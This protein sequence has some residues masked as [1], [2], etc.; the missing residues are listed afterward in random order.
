MD[1]LTWLLLAVLAVCGLA[2]WWVRSSQ[3]RLD[4]TLHLAGL[5]APVTVMRDDRGI[6]HIT[7][8]NVHDLYMAQGYVMAQDRLWQMDLM[9]RLGEG[10]L[11]EIFGPA[12]LDLDRKNRE[13][14]LGRTAAAEA[15][16]L[17][18]QEA[19]LLDDFAA[20]VNA[21]IQSRRYR[22]P[23]EFWLLRYRPQA[24]RA[25]DSLALAAYMYQVLASGYED[26]LTREALTAKL[27]P[28]LASQAFPSHSPWDVV[29]GEAPPPPA[30][31]FG[32]GFGRGGFGQR[33]FPNPTPAPVPPGPERR[34]RPRRSPAPL[35]G[36][37]A[38]TSLDNLP[39]FGVPAPE[40]APASLRGG[41][42]NWVL[43]GERSFTGKPILANDPHLQFQI[44]GLWWAVQLTAPG[45][46]VEGVAIAGVPGVI[47]GH[48]D[49]IAWGVTNTRAD[50]QDLYRETLDGKGNVK[51]PSGWQP[52][53]HWRETIAVKGAA[54]VKLDIPVTP[55]GPI[56]SRDDGGPLALDWSLYAP[57]ALQSI[58]VFLAIDEA[59]NWDQFKAALAQFPGPAQNFVYADDAGHIAYQCAGWIPL[60]QGFDGALPVPGDQAAYDWHGWIPFD[61]LPEVVDPAR[62]VL[63]TANSRITPDN[64]PYTISTDWDSPNRTRRIYQLLGMLNHWNASAMGRV[65]T[66][67]ISEQDADFARALLAAGQASETQGHALT[68]STRQAL[69]LLRGFGGAMAATSP[70][71]TLAYQT[72]HEFVRRVLAA[73]VGDALARQY[74]WDEAPVFE[75][76][77][78]ANHPAPWLPSA[79]AGPEGRGW[80]GLLLDSLQSVVER[81]TLEPNQM[82]WGKFETLTIKH[83]VLSQIPLIRRYADLG[84]VE[85]SGSPLTV[86]Q[87]RNV[88]LGDESDLGPSMRFVANV[89]SWDRSTLTLVA[90]ESGRV[91]TNHYR[92]EFD[93]YLHGRQLPLWFTRAAVAAHAKHTLRLTP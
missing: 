20:G 2:F 47:I 37:P 68:G 25:Q 31:N 74:R 63:A 56:V 50:V 58:H 72:R 40:L 8:A 36:S 19:E 73:K 34:F 89:G 16:R 32:R 41:S 81:T 30:R 62:G 76:W 53:Q 75:R 85:I 79:Y 91:L 84:P 3:P 59:G 60:R 51:T 52:L 15:Q 66:D 61:K 90:G 92:D 13:L 11:A 49:H 23:L 24:W 54:P 69:N 57:G 46:N 38:R 5:R 70:A 71:P 29:P 65:Q 86:K 33:G 55:H 7:A 39:V 9:R 64:Y 44:P 10:R 4:G 45:L 21:N 35:P 80:N 17:Q 22:W 6:P 87:A 82:R 43:S 83:P 18:P 12:A 28:E 78:L 77:L 88:M 27:G 1:V 48:N 26:K 14:G 42:N 93:A 67:V